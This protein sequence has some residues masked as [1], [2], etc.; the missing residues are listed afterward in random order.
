M[1]WGENPYFGNTRMVDMFLLKATEKVLHID[2][3]RENP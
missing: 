1:I 3:C 2:E